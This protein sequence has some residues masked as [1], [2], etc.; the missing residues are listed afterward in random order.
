MTIGPVLET[1]LVRGSL[2]NYTLWIA[3][4]DQLGQDRRWV[5]IAQDDDKT[6]LDLSDEESP[7]QTASIL[8]RLQ[9]RIMADADTE[10]P[11]LIMS[12]F[13]KRNAQ[14]SKKRTR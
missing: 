8:C 14:R 13:G 7:K 3:A 9:N 1:K 4:P 11:E 6:V 10:E 12:S 5:L 2:H